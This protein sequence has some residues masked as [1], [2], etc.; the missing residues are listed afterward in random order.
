MFILPLVTLNDLLLIIPI[1]LISQCTKP[2]KC[3]HCEGNHEAGDK[4]CKIQSDE[5]QI[6]EMIVLKKI[7]RK[8]ARMQVL[9]QGG[10][11]RMPAADVVVVQEQSRERWEQEREK[12]V[13]DT[14]TTKVDAYLEGKAQ[15]ES[16]ALIQLKET[17]D[18]LLTAAKPNATPV[19]QEPDLEKRLEEKIFQKFAARL[20]NLEDTIKQQGEDI[21]R[22]QQDKVEL[23][24]RQ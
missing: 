2:K 20:D 7:S 10:A 1:K 14:I 23:E 24:K 16:A 17:V 6:N 22:L 11:S 9:A 5:K 8:E 4:E 18:Q 13:F 21:K 3:F 19:S 15:A 12:Q